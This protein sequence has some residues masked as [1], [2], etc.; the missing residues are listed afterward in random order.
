MNPK[1][2]NITGKQD[3][4]A[5]TFGKTDV[6]LVLAEMLLAIPDNRK[7]FHSVSSKLI[8]YA[9]GLRTLSSIPRDA[10]MR[11][12]LCLDWRNK[13]LKIFESLLTKEQGQTFLLNLA[14]TKYKEIISKGII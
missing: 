2:N 4:I 3:G 8:D 13:Y 12:V 6:C 7:K 10:P 9:D 11:T 1:I 14:K 5:Y